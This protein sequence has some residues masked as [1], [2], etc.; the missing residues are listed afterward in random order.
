MPSSFGECFC[1]QTKV[2][3]YIIRT[4]AMLNPV[5]YGS[6]QGRVD[7]NEPQI[8]SVLVRVVSTAEAVLFCRQYQAMALCR[9][10]DVVNLEGKIKLLASLF[11]RWA[12]QL[13]SCTVLQRSCS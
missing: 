13:C 3:Y 12:A 8:S 10:K 4:Y 9:G 11:W 6:S 7:R 2:R 1:W 5:P